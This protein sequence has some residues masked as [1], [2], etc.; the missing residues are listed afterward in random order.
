LLLRL[1][2]GQKSRVLNHLFTTPVSR[3]SAGLSAEQLAGVRDWVLA[4]EAAEPGEKRSNRGGWHSTGNLFGRGEPEAAALREAATRALGAYV[5]QAFDYKGDVKL[6][7][8]AWTV[9]NRAGDFN[10]PHNHAPHLLSGA[11]YV[12]VPAGMRGG[13]IVF[14]D[15]RLALNAHESETMRQLKLKA[16][17][18]RPGIS[19]AP[20][21]GEVL[22]FP[23]WL[24]HYVE[25]FQ[26]DDPA[27]VRI[28][29]S[30]NASV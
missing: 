22:V 24:R 19:V 5:S 12:A 4:L 7:M 15:P 18:S 29:V 27:A 2:F 6:T 25:P 8:L 23:S 28:V 10:A 21:A 30:F 9:V 26:C 16:P 17:W 3:D 13:E 1:G 11:L 20:A 14:E